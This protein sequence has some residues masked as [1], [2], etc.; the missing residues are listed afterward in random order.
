M[1]ANLPETRPEG[2]AFAAETHVQPSGALVEV[3][4]VTFQGRPFAA[5]GSVQDAARGLILGYAVEREPHVYALTIWEGASI[6][7]LRLVRRWAQRGFYGARIDMC[8]WSCTVSGRTYSGR[9]A[10]PDMFVCMR[11]RV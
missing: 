1:K 8:A 5:L 10:G 7:P 4:T 9:N 2:L 11:A 6:A 3:G